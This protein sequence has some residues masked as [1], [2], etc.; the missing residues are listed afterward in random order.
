MME[1]E[2]KKFNARRAQWLCERA[3]CSEKLAKI[4]FDQIVHRA[5][6]PHPSQEF[7]DWWKTQMEYR[8]DGIDEVRARNCK[9]FTDRFKEAVEI[10][11]ASMPIDYPQ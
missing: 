3:G 2:A 6:N 7:I 5:W 4:H 10:G 9:C 8:R 1:T 11:V